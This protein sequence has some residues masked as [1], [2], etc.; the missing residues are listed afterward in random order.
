MLRLLSR[1]LL[2]APRIA[3]V[4]CTS[5]VGAVHDVLHGT[6][7][8]KQVLQ[9]TVT[10]L[11]YSNEVGF[12]TPKRKPEP[13]AD[14]SDFTVEKETYTVR[15]FGDRLLESLCPVIAEGA[16]VCTCGQ[17]RMNPQKDGEDKEF[18]FPFIEVS[19]EKKGKVVVLH[20]KR[21]SSEGNTLP[22]SAAAATATTTAA[23]QTETQ[24]K[25]PVSPPQEP[26]SHNHSTA[27][28]SPQTAPL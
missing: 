9:F 20:S 16:I 25:A 18:F 6:L 26:P 15:C 27:A 21:K 13:K 12:Y 8:T 17:L 19:E 5:I 7:G 2:V 23:P 4:N 10:S 14:D 22:A 28:A 24:Q 1:A 11:A 3:S